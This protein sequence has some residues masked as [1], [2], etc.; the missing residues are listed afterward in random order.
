MNTAVNIEEYINTRVNC[1]IEWYEKKACSCKRKYTVSQTF[2]IILAALIPLL[3]SYAD[4]FQIIGFI[5]G[6]CGAAIAV[7]KSL[8]KLYKWQE[9]W[10]A[11]RTASDLLH[12]QKVLF[13][14]HSA[15][16]NTR[17][18]TIENIFIHNIEQIISAERTQWKA[19]NQE[20]TGAEEEQ[21]DA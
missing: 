21:N 12:Y 7:I 10:I 8:S 5:V 4:N 13:K 1:Q 19:F 6:V 9:N 20:Q 17:P 11:Y 15:P 14:T 3:S 16:Y 2:E 18:E